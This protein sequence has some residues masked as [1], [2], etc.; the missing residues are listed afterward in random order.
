MNYCMFKYE[1]GFLVIYL[2]VCFVICGEGV[3]SLW[4]FGIRDMI[5]IKYCRQEV[6]LLDLYYQVDLNG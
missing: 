3:S 2:S 4:N 5:G 1:M 6:W